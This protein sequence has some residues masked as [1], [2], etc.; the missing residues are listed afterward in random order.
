[1]TTDPM[2]KNIPFS[3][4]LDLA[5]LVTYQ[6]GQVVSR[7]LAQNEALSITLFALDEGEAISTHITPGDALVYVLDGE[8]VLEIGD[9]RVPTPK[10]RATVMPANVPHA[11]YAEE[12]FKM[13]LIVV[14]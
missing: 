14:K 4:P 13:L 5:N 3:E 7:T 9:E 10:G 6:T 12:R 2:I 8:V 1:M 11:L